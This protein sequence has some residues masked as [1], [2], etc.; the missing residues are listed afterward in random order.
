MSVP[1]AERAARLHAQNQWA[2]ETHVYEPHVTGIPPVRQYF[3]E[4][5][6]RREFALEL[7][8]TQLRAQQYGTVL[9]QIWLVLNPVLFALVYFVLID[10]VRAGDQ[11]PA[12]FAH[13]L[14]GVF[15]YHLVTTAIREGAISLT[16]SGRLILNSSFPRMLLPL[17]AVISALKQF[18]PCI[19]LYVVTHW[20]F[21]RPVNENTLWVI[22][23]L[24]MML[25]LGTG[26]ALLAA[27]VQVYF[28]DLKSFLPYA[29]RLMLF[30][31]PVLYF[32]TRV[33]DQYSWLLDVNPVGRILA[34]W[35]QILYFGNAPTT[36][37]MLVATAWSVGSLVVG[38]L[39]FM[40]REREFAVR[41]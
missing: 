21:D 40:S 12:V 20:A 18:L 4:V 7:S 27:A 28:R 5:W 9:G 38:A 8:R 22:V 32:V 39:F 35:E 6:K 41:L 3:S 25:M 19:P 36:H 30:G 37:S 2:E 16:R 34:A 29:L 15:A 17:S 1:A 13:L 26:L 23:L 11:E 31:A 24:A 10:I 14:A 33:P